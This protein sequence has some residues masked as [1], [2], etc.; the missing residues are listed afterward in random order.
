MGIFE[1]LKAK[2]KRDKTNE[3][4]FA[5]KSKKEVEQKENFVPNL[6]YVEL[7]SVDWA[8]FAG[9]L[10]REGV[11]S[12]SYDKN[13]IS[14]EYTL[15]KDNTPVVELTFKSKT[16]DSVRKVQL[17][18]DKAFLFVNGVVEAF[19]E[20]QR[21]KNLNR[22]WNEYQNKIRYYCTL[23]TNREGYFHKMRGEKLMLE[24]KRMMD[25]YNLSEREQEFLE[26]WQDIQFNYFGYVNKFEKDIR[27]NR[28]N[29]VGEVPAFIKHGYGE[30]FPFTPKTLEYCILNMTD[31]CKIGEGEFLVEFEKKCRDIQKHSCYQSEDWDKVIE[32]GK[33]HVRDKHI[34]YLC[35]EKV[36]ED[37]SLSSDS[38][39]SIVVTKYPD[40]ERKVS[41]LFL[42]RGPIVIDEERSK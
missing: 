20:T 6:S 19:P 8:E 30:A 1:F 3:M 22:L 10:K 4:D 23:E 16:S 39:V 26:K 24:A 36:E 17:F 15:A 2:E 38:N 18:N 13:P 25:M 35:G 14:I 11:L 21:S 28:S 5:D 12:N 9:T 37:K 29:Y 40:G 41:C 34:R 31:G 42:D 27:C 33:K 32:F 7:Q